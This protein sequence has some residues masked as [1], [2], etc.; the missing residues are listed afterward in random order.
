MLIIGI[1]GSPRVDGNTDLILNEALKAAVSNGAE[2]KLIRISDYHLEPCNACM[3]C[4]KTGK[5]IIPDD[6]QKLYDEI[7]KANGVI[8][9]SP[10]YFQGVTGQMKIFI[11]RIGFLAQQG[12]DWILRGRLEA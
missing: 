7:K 1:S 5:C 11:D 12:R 2:V 6:G 9:A 3:T 8:L 4:F 10:S